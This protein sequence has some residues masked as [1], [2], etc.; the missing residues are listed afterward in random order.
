MDTLQRDERS[1][2]RVAGDG[3][4][5]GL[6]FRHAVAGLNQEIH[7]RLN[8][9]FGPDGLGATGVKLQCSQSISGDAAKH[10]VLYGEHAERHA[11]RSVKFLQHSLRG[12]PVSVSEH[13]IRWSKLIGRVNHRIGQR[14]EVGLVEAVVNPRERTAAATNGV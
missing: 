2:V 13:F 8:T 12:E 11:F 10:I 14:E 4:E 3:A 5:H 1:G 7:R 6:S 9:G